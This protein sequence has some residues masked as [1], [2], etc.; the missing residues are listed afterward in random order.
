M[1][2]QMLSMH[3]TQIARSMKTDTNNNNNT[4][5]TIGQIQEVADKSNCRIALHHYTDSKRPAAGLSFCQC[6]WTAC[7]SLPDPTRPEKNVTKAVWG[8]GVKDVSVHTVL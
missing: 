3:T 6:D 1:S 5:N 4:S 2:K 8:E 7:N